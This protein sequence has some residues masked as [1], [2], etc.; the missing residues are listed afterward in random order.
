MRSVQEEK[1]D[2]INEKTHNKSRGLNLYLMS[3]VGYLSSDVPKLS[4]TILVPNDELVNNNY[5]Q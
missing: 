1:V 3:L 5:E 4:I 2:D